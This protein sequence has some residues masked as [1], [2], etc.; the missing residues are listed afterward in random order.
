[1]NITQGGL[2]ERLDPRRSESKRVGE[3]EQILGGR[4]YYHS[5]GSPHQQPLPH[6]NPYLN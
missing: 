1:M 3:Q 5:L 6:T 4:Q 2:W